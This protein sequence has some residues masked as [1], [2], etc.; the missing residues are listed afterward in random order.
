[1]PSAKQTRDCWKSTIRT[2]TQTWYH[3]ISHNIILSIFDTYLHIIMQIFDIAASMQQTNWFNCNN[4]QKLYWLRQK[5]FAI[6]SEI[7]KTSWKPKQAKNKTS[8]NQNS[9]TLNS[10]NMNTASVI[11]PSCIRCLTIFLR[12]QAYSMHQACSMQQTNR[13]QPLANTL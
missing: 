12:K 3:T 13:L 5:H 8:I 10:L 1:M 7:F 4:C 6:F 11:L 9:L 2:V